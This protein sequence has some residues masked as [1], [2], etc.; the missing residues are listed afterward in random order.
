MGLKIKKSDGLVNVYDITV[1][2]NHNFYANNILVHNCIEIMQASLPTY[3]PQCTLASVNLAEHDSLKSIA[4]S[5]KVLVRALNKVID[6]NKWSDDWSKKAGEDQRA[7]A[8]G[9]AGLA[10]FF[11]KKKI[12]FESEEAKQWNHDIFETMYKAAVEESMELA[13]EEGKNYPAWE[14]SKYSKGE[15]YIDGW[16][17]IEKG[18]PI[19]MRNSLLIGLMPTASSAILLGSFECFEPVTSNIFTRMVGDGEFIVVNKY[20]ARELDELG[21]W[22]EEIRDQIIA[23]EGSVQEIQEIPQDIRYRYK[24]VWELPQKVLLELAIIRN[25]FVDQSQSMN[26]YHRDA[27]YS[28]ISSALVFA[29]KNGLKTG[30]YYTRTESKLGKNKKLSA[31]DN[32]KVNT[33][34]KPENSMFDCAGGGCSA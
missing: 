8:V 13:M 18:V 14:G 22:T 32:A 33:V 20:L 2:D 7:I 3:T 21:L 6:N 11:A 15:T 10:D 30:A 34:K 25:K 16:S 1:K 5:V 26:V 17:P 24:T 23:N 27:K 19:P 31:S 9:V 4:K 29:W 28:K 12:S